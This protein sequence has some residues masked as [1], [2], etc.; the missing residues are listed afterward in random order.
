MP[1]V[2]IGFDAFG[3]LFRVAPSLGHQYAHVMHR[4]LPAGSRLDTH[5]LSLSISQAIKYH[6]R[7]HFNYGLAQGWTSKHWWNQVLLSAH[8]SYPIPI[9]ADKSSS[10]GLLLLERCS[11]DLYAHF[12]GKDPYELYPHVRPTLTHLAQLY[13][14]FVLSNCDE[15]LADILKS[16]DL[17]RYFMFSVDSRSAGY[18]K[19]DRRIFELCQTRIGELSQAG[20][21]SIVYYVGDDKDKDVDGPRDLGWTPILFNPHSFTEP[22]SVLTFSRFDQLP[23]LLP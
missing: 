23:N 2:W 18:A 3:T 22:G 12:R 17:D 14:L 10:D 16:L 4:H 5:R 11:D 6:T 20:S 13:N 21:V 1:R 8:A 15:R 7:Q 19:P 9:P